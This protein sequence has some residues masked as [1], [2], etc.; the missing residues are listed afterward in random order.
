MD[1]ASLLQQLLNQ[2]MPQA[3][4]RGEMPMRAPMQAA[5][6]RQ[7]MP[8][9]QMANAPQPAMPRQALQP[10]QPQARPQARQGGG[11]SDFISGLF[12]SE[13]PRK[14]ATIAWLQKQG[15]DEGTAIL[16]SE[17]R[18]M[19]NRFMVSRMSG[20]DP[21]AALDTELKRIQID[22]ARK[23]LAAAPE[24]K[25]TDDEREYRRAVGQGYTGSFMDFMKTMKEYGRNQINID[26]G[27]KLPNGYRW[28][29]PNKQELGV[30]PIP[31]G[32]GEQIPGE[33]AARIGL[34]DKF[35]TE[36]EPGLRTRLKSGDV[37]GVW[38]RLQA[39]FNQSSDQADTYRKFELGTEALQRMLTGAGMNVAEAENYARRFLPGYTDDGPSSAKKL[40][41][42]MKA[43]QGAREMAMRGRG[44]QAAAPQNDGWTD[45]GG[46]VKIR[47]K[48]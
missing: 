10:A 47:R 19:L 26:T 41:D 23:N 32:P 33:L 35:I 22:Q 31:G 28:V 38:D 39:G 27:V 20:R 9:P 5:Q 14:N 6:Q 8:V 4:M 7:P 43:L 40:D 21:D 48:Q 24:E 42:L 44:G 11:L 1:L 3:P 18:D 37:T 17:D 29:D 13:P 34:A 16:V 45:A 15:L 2:E 36:V 46:G 30:E 25:M 12:S